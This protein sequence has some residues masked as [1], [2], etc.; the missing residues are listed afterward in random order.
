MQQMSELNYEL[1]D[2][3]S[4]RH[5]AE[6][7]QVFEQLDIEVWI[8]QGTLLGAVRDDG[9]IPWD[10]DIDLSAWYGDWVEQPELQEKLKN[11]GFELIYLRKSRSLRIEPVSKYPGWRQV[12]VHLYKVKA[13]QA[14]TYFFE[15]DINNR[16][17]KWL[18]KLI[19]KL[20]WLQRAIVQE[21][22]SLKLLLKRPE[23]AN[24][25]Y[26]NRKGGVR[27]LLF[28][29]VKMIKHRVFLYRFNRFSKLRSVQTP[30]HYYHSL[31][32]KTLLKGE[33]SAP[34][35]TNTYLAFKYGENW[36]IPIQNYDWRNDGSVAACNNVNLNFSS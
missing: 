26:R 2:Q 17:Q 34:A 20:D 18:F 32:R 31:T 25:V 6:V 36:R 13:E 4:R 11:A 14:C 19:M 10:W 1:I 5:L 28:R 9:F 24:R 27:L 12:D 29:F 33:Y 30:V 23:L 22:P 15:F 8:D 35:D 21:P 7:M 3:M 16:T